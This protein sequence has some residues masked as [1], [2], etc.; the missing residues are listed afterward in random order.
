MRGED[1]DPRLGTAAL[2]PDTPV[3]AGARYAW[4]IVYTVKEARLCVGGSVRVEIPQGFSAPAVDSARSAGQITVS[5]SRPDVTL[6]VQLN[7]PFPRPEPRA[8]LRSGQCVYVLVTDGELVAEET[9]TVRY[10]RLDRWLPLGARAQAFSGVAEFTVAVD[11]DGTHRGRHTGYTLVGPPLALRV[12]GGPPQRVLL[13]A[14][15]AALPARAQQAS[16]ATLLALDCHANP[17][18]CGVIEVA[19]GSPAAPRRWDVGTTGPTLRLDGTGV[20]ETAAGSVWRPQVHVTIP[21]LAPELAARGGPA[22]WL[23]PEDVAALPA[24]PQAIRV[25]GNPLDGPAGTARTE[26]LYWGDLHTHTH[27]AE[28]RGSPDDLCVFARD[29]ALLDFVAVHDHIEDLEDR[30]WEVLR[31]AAARHNA[32]GRFVTLLGYEYSPDWP[33]SYVHGDKNVYFPGETG[34]LRPPIRGPRVYENG[35]Q[36]MDEIA[37]ALKEAG[38]MMMAHAHARNVASFYDPDLLRLLELYSGWGNS[39]RFESA[40]AARPLLPALA[41]DFAGHYVQDALAAGFRAG[42]VAA[43]DDHSGH[44][45]LSTWHPYG[46][47]R[48]PGGLTAVDAPALTRAAI[49]EALWERRCYGTTGARIVVRFAVAGATMGRELQLDGSARTLPVTGRV[50]GTAPLARLTV[51][52]DNQDW[53]TWRSPPAQAPWEI[54]FAVEDAPQAMLPG[55][56]SYYLR[57][58]QQDGERAWTSPVWIDV[59]VSRTRD[60]RHEATREEQ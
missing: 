4:S 57:V 48:Y 60:G 44:P 2:V 26:H 50:L 17:A 8:F 36:A 29:R 46:P 55:P 27:L 45:G 33:R 56:H 43:S 5:A 15:E 41:Q 14:R 6:T 32:A 20:L 25:T 7:S 30:D 59:S 3:T 47:R 9:L 23:L 12:V 42:L 54:S 28:G 51:V 21:G 19:D 40:A 49:W 52:R 10:G 24:A 11:V 34:M 16:S 38:A 22:G 39:E 58:E 31:E 35:P 53:H 13:V 18:G 1:I 37:A